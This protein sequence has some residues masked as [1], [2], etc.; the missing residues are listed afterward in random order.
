MDYLDPNTVTET[1]RTEAPRNRN[2]SGY[3]NK[4]PS[5]WLVK[6]GGRWHRVY[7]IQYSNAGSA[8][9]L[10]KKQRVWLGSYEP[11]V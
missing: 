4:I 9:I 5:E 2:A 3:G 11:K 7:V 8:Y 10:Q 6:V 1:R